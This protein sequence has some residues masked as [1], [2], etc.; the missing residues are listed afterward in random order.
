MERGEL[1]SIVSDVVDGRGYLDGNYVCAGKKQ[2]MAFFSYTGVIY[3][4]LLAVRR[5]PASL[6]I[7]FSACDVCTYSM[8]KEEKCL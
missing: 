4:A 2:A 8:F 1:L 6:P 7:E 3:H 5:F